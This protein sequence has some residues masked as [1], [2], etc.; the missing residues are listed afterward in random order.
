MENQSEQIFDSDTSFHLPP[1]DLIASNDADL[2]FFD[3]FSPPDFFDTFS[4]PAIPSDWSDF[5]DHHDSIP[6]EPEPATS[7]VSAQP[8]ATL[9]N[10]KITSFWKIA[11]PAKS[12]R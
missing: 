5:N 6:E 9:P 2:D 7:P 10:S 4:P 1:E 8:I 11:T 12:K 3:T